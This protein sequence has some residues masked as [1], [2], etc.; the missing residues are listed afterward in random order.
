MRIPDPRAITFPKEGY[1]IIFASKQRKGKREE[2]EDAVCN[3]QNECFAI[4]DGVGG[5][6]HGQV[7]ASLA[8]TTAVWA[9]KHVRQRPAFWKDK[10]LFLKRIFRTTNMRIWHK[11]R[12]PGFKD[13]MATTLLVLITSG[14]KFWIGN[15]GDSSAYLFREGYAK[16]LTKDDTDEY[17]MLTKVLGVKRFGLIPSTVRDELFINDTILL[18]S[19]GV[20]RNV[21]TELLRKII[22]RTGDIAFSLEHACEKILDSAER[23]DSRD[24]MTVYLIKKVASS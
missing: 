14:K 21:D 24:N 1:K 9:Y 6:P 13:G 11:Q 20:T 2:Q 10:P 8:A 18:A 4:A 17:G 22:F 5:M 15:A 7:A 12:D 16:K 23:N 19:D 3:F